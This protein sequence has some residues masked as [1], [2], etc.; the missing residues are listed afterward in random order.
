MVW[1]LWILSIKPVRI[2]FKATCCSCSF[3]WFCWK[4]NRGVKLSVPG[5]L[6]LRGGECIGF[7]TLQRWLKSWKNIL[8]TWTGCVPHPKVFT[9][10]GSKALGLSLSVF[11]M[12]FTV[13][14]PKLKN[15]CQQRLVLVRGLVVV[16]VWGCK[17]DDQKKH[18]VG[19][20]TCSTQREIFTLLVKGDNLQEW[21]RTYIN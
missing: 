12:G 9:S 17:E 1:C 14:R 15:C 2:W 16:R 8:Y 3:L 7:L 4:A 21:I 6:Q 20:F 11:I 18:C 5:C 19:H 13:S 10:F